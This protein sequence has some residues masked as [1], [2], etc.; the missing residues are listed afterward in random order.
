MSDAD[1]HPQHEILIDGGQYS[2]DKKLAPIINLI[3]SKLNIETYES[4]ENYG[5]YL[6]DLGLTF[7][8]ESQRDYA[9][10]EFYNLDDA[11]M[12]LQWVKDK[13][14]FIHELGQK[15]SSETVP[16]AWELKARFSIPWHF[17]V[18][19]PEA[20]IPSLEEL[21]ERS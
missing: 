7:N 8:H 16:G 5:E 17:W 4:C 11:I 10:I 6:R 18:W 21:L 12:F 15:V 13:A 20:D 9:Y 1:F 19:F 3:N 2:V 14:T